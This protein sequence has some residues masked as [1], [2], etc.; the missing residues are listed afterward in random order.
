MFLPINLNIV[1]GAQKIHLLETVLLGNHNI[2]FGFEIRKLTFNLIMDSTL[3][4]VYASDF[5]Q[6]EILCALNGIF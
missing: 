1:L 4:S 2:Q 3:G 5:T 6:C